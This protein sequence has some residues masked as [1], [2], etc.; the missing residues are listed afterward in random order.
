[1]LAKTVGIKPI[2][3]KV[4][5]P[6]ANVANTECGMEYTVEQDANG[7]SVMVGRKII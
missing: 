2:I 4:P 7:N 1:M 3:S 5:A 6:M